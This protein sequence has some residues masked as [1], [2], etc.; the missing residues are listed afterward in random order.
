MP[1]AEP[2]LW[3]HKKVETWA[4]KPGLDEILILAAEDVRII[5]NPP[6]V[7]PTLAVRIW[8]LDGERALYELSPFVVPVGSMRT[9]AAPYPI[10]HA[11]AIARLSDFAV[12]YRTHAGE[13]AFLDLELG[14]G[15]A[16]EIWSTH[17]R[18]RGAG[19]GD[20]ELV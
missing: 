10:D 3:K 12:V 17:V 2:T 5:I 6:H 20:L 15:L 14:P 16:A 4:C 19:V 8:A 9:E 7:G 18:M 13:L 11:T 1:S